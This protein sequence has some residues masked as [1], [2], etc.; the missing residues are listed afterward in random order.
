MR[1]KTNFLPIM[2]NP[3]FP[4][5]GPATGFSNGLQPKSKFL[6]MNVYP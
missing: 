1:S 4:P 5:S 6:A 3:L 2:N